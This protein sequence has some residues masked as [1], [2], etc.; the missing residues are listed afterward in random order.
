MKSDLAKVS[1]ALVSA[2]FLLGCQDQGSDPVGP[3]VA[4]QFNRPTDG[5][6]DHGG[7][8]G[9]DP[10][11]FTATFGGDVTA[12]VDLVGPHGQKSFSKML[13]ERSVL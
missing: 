11:T 1:L 10:L 7:D 6:H 5:V 2:V 9:G 13:L 12:G 4:P 3:D 8:G